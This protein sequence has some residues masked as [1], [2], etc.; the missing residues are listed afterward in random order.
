MRDLMTMAGELPVTGA[1]AGNTG[2][3]AGYGYSLNSSPS[4]A[5]VPAADLSLHRRDADRRGH[6]QRAQQLRQT[7]LDDGGR[8]EKREEADKESAGRA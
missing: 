3:G 8:S 7:E 2:A 4:G 6:G 5:D 1:V